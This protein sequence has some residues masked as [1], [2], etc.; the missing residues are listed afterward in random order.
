MVIIIAYILDLIIGDP[1][2]FYHPVRFI[3][4][5]INKLEN[6]LRN[7]INF[8][9][10]YIL[11]G[12]LTFIIVGGSFLSVGAIKYITYKI[13]Y[14]LGFIIE[15]I[16]IYFTF[17]ARSLYDESMIVYKA[18]VNK[19]IEKARKLLSYIVGR[20]TVNL[21]EEEITTAAVE[22]VSE[23]TNDGVIAPIL[24]AFI[25]G[26]PLAYAYKAINTLDSMVAYK[27]EKYNKF[28]YCSA[29]LDDIANF[30]PA[31][32]AS[33]LMII[34]SFIL[35]LDYKNAIRVF[36]ED[37]YKHLSPNSAQTEAVAAGALG[38]RLGGPNKYGGKIVDKPYIGRY[39]HKPK[40]VH[41]KL[42][43]R[44]MLLSSFILMFIIIILKYFMEWL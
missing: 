38:I 18:L 19:D 10:D 6:F 4:L 33:L 24:F 40:A 20:D 26:A 32:I 35:R 37:R 11:G 27:N 23:N 5:L 14:I 34:S 39:I 9:N 29:K 2:S 12:I 41:I 8:L 13:N 3:G 21:S 30:I 43:N 28:G 25:G 17:A 7:K 15:S 44:I 42:C 22:T 36:K 1:K 16:L 31:R